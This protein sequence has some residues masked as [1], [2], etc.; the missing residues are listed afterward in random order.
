MTATPS[1]KALLKIYE[2]L[3]TEVQEHF[4]H[5]PK[6]IKEFPYDVSLAYAFLK[7]EQAQNRALYGGV[8]KIHRGEAGFV[9]RVLNFRHLTRNG[10]K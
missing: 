7:I 2:A 4:Q 8:V 3:P 9:H 1:Y 6:L 5:I 10:F